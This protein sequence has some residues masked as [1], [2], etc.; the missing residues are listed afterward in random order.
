MAAALQLYDLG[1]SKQVDT[2]SGT[3]AS[4]TINGITTERSSNTFTIDGVT[5]NLKQTFTD[6]VIVGVTSDVSAVYDNIKSFIDSYNEIITAISAK[7]N[8][9][10]NRNYQPLSEE[11]RS[12]LSENEVEKWDKIAKAGWLQNDATLKGLLSSMRYSM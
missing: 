11:E 8:E 2:I 10:R 7:T 6:P 1:S 9:T 12:S 5:F 3:N 4:F